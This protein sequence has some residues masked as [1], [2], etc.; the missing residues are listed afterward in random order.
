MLK[1]PAG[2]IDS[3]RNFNKDGITA[4]QKAALKTPEI[5]N[6]K[7]FSIEVMT[8]KS[9]AA[10]NLAGWVINIV[11]Y[12]DIFEVVEPLK[13]EAEASQAEAQ[14][15]GEELKV[16]Q[17]RVAEIVAK[18]NAL[19]ANLAEAEAK[20]AAVVAQATGL[21][22]SLDLA[23]RLVNGLADENVRWQ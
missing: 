20:K 7:D 23:N 2:F 16:V 19:K 9:M 5:L 21:Q 12:H 13:N 10:A 17:D 6:H 11:E 8:R 15:K 4:A 14:Q 18:V 3:L 22:Q 1:P